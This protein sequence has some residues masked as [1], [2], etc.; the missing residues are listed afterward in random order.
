MN[1]CDCQPVSHCN[2]EN[3]ASFAQFGVQSNPAS[4][5]ELPMFPLFRQGT[6]IILDSSKIILSP[7]YLY[8]IDYIF[9]ATTEINSYM[10]ITPVINGARNLLY[11][12]FAPSGA[13]ERNAAASGSFTTNAAG[14]KEA[15]LSF[16]LTYPEAVR[17]IDISG[18]VSVTQ[19]YKISANG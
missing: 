13:Q 4:G 14:S 17:N 15:S 19:L 18:T 1:H 3:M 7:G 16:Y 8:L 5:T 11:S 6:H 10:Q 12:F 2:P 9:L